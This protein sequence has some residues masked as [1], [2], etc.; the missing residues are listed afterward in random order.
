M[1][2][3]VGN[4]ELGDLAMNALREKGVDASYV[5]RGTQPTGQVLV[6]LDS[7]GHA[8][9]EFAADTAW[10]NLKWSAEWEQLA[11]AADA[12]CFGTLAQ[13]SETSRETIQTFVSKIPEESLRIFD[14]NLRPPFFSDA[15]ILQSLSLANV[16]KLNDEELPVLANQFGFSGTPIEVMQ[17]LAKRFGLRCVALTRGAKGA[18]LVSEDVVSEQSG[19]T[20]KV[21]DTVGAGDAFTATLAS[22]LLVGGDLDTINR[23]ACSVAAFVCSQPGATPNIP[24]EVIG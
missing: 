15:I 14:V 13:R 17:Q 21:V 5:T 3:S 8:R 18:I 12:C 23:T 10:D 16:L 22:G 11:A 2:S 9:Y 24:P 1:A 4:D 19:V 7:Q 20:S 6:Q